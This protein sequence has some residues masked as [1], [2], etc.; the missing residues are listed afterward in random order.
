MRIVVMR[1]ILVFFVV[2]LMLVSIFG[3][4]IALF[5]GMIALW[6]MHRAWLERLVTTIRRSLFLLFLLALVVVVTMII[7]V[8]IL[9]LVVVMIL[10]LAFSAVAT[11]TPV[12]LFC[13]MADLLIVS[14]PERLMHLTLH[15][16]LNLM[17]A[18]LC[19]GAICH[20]QVKNVL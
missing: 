8:A 7:V 6:S 13:D 11:V 4:L 12:T 20:L 15:V 14:P 17:L 16:M 10:R 3:V 1:L 9:P 18:F 5:E 19:K 2:G